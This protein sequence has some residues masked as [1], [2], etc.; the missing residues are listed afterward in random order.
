M[1]MFY[2]VFDVPAPKEVERRRSNRRKAKQTGHLE[3]NPQWEVVL[4]FPRE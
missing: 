1:D 3:K 4:K 2:D